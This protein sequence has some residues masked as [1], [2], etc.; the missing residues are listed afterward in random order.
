MT[1]HNRVAWHEGL[2]I[3]QHHLQQ[4]ARHTDWLI[5]HR[6]D[7]LVPHGWGVTALEID[8][9][10]LAQRQIGLT[11]CA[12]VL[13]DGTPFSIPDE[14]DTP[15]PL[16]IPAGTRGL[17]V[18]LALPLASPRLPD[19]PM[20]QGRDTRL[21]H[22][23]RDMTLADAVE[24]GEEAS[25][26]LARP[27]FRLLPDTENL[28]GFTS[29]PIARITETDA[30]RGIILD[31]GF[32]PP[33]LSVQSSP[34]LA[35]LLERVDELVDHR[36][37]R[38]VETATEMEALAGDHLLL[39]ALNRHRPV[40]H[41][42]IHG[43]RLHP[44]SLYRSLLSLCGELATLFAADRKATRFPAYEHDDLAGTF[45]PVTLELGRYL[46][47][48]LPVPVVRLPLQ[49]LEKHKMWHAHVRDPDLFSGW[50]FFLSVKAGMP[51]EQLARSFAS[52]TKVSGPAKLQSF[53]NS[54]SPALA[55][56]IQGDVPARITDRKDRLFLEFKRQGDHW[57]AI[58]TEKAI[59]I[60]VS[61][62]FRDA[63]L[64][65]W[66]CREVRS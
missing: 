64:Q 24:G 62:M 16:P 3:R 42:L 44:E 39:W 55:L 59:G 47:A 7:P 21:R 33:T 2:F 26:E 43:G 22:N 60:A 4:S 19:M 48:M 32:I 65:L 14:A 63:D 61:D 29:L 34:P 35:E 49:Y 28:A 41:H 58:I 30:E 56:E 36:I 52:N 8:R 57:Q 27:R 53:R 13:R 20:G 40:L 5:Q 25:I 38:L 6:V 23:R 17:R 1:S 15:P 9:N 31:R 50:R 18:H 45:N 37:T 54:N 66:A 12:G 51:M 46:S 10:L 11:A